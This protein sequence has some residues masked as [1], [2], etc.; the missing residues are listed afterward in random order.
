MT[1]EEQCRLSYYHKIAEISTHKNVSLVQNVENK[2][3]YVRK[4]QQVYN[5]SVYEYLRNSN[6]PHIPKIYECVEDHGT[7]IIIEDY[8]QG[9]SLQEIITVQGALPKNLAIQY[10]ITVC[11]VLEE[12]HSLPEPVIH[13]DLKPENII[14]QDGG[15]LRLIDFN[16]AKKYDANRESDTVIIGT[17]KYAAPEQYG[18][19]Q[20]DARTDIYAIGVMLNYMLVGMYPEINTYNED[21]RLEKIITKCVAFDPENRFQTVMDLR[22]ALQSAMGSE[23]APQQQDRKDSPNPKQGKRNSWLPPGFRTR[24]P[25]KIVTGSFCYLML[26]YCCLTMDITNQ[27]GS[28]AVGAELWLNRIGALLCAV[29]AIFYW[30]DYRG[31]Q[32]NT[33]L[34]DKGWGKI[35]MGI[36][37]PFMFTVLV[38]MVIE[39]FS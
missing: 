34:T 12:L 37:V 33:P 30:F 7:L 14:I 27:D 4:E 22:A 29:F 6:N 26:F 3:I 5:K 36:L 11:D 28:L 10:M 18:F 31:I 1:L 9:D 32:R 13:R 17:R 23:D 19:Q 16:T 20:S 2:K 21:K 38:V 39:L 24:T 15:Y 25:W 35:L 8:I